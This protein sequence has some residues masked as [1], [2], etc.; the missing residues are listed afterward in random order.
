MTNNF[1]IKFGEPEQ[2]KRIWGAF[3]VALKAWGTTGKDFEI[4][5]REPE[6]ERSPKALRGYWRLIGVITKHLNKT[7]LEN[8][9]GEDVSDMFKENIGFTYKIDKMPLWSRRFRDELNNGYEIFFWA[10]D[11]CYSL[12]KKSEEDVIPFSSNDRV[13]LGFR[14]KVKTRSLKKNKGCT[15]KDMEKLI[16]EVLRFG[17]GISDC[18][19][20]NEE[21]R[22]FE[23]YYGIKKTN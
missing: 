9:E 16:G 23:K 4:V 1:I 11:G 5:I 8:W 19:L 17:A 3:K 14:Y 21:Q 10:D 7:N 15:L 6:A 12:E 22:N 20:K 13:S 18:E 2:K